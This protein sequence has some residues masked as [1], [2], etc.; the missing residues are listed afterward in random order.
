MESTPAKP[1]SAEG[2]GRRALQPVRWMLLLLALLSLA[3]AVVGIFVPVLPT[4]PFVLL[5]AWAA[6]R[7][8]P[9][10]EQS[11]LRHRSFGPMIRDWQRSGVVGRPAKRAAT[12][13]MAL[14]ALVIVWVVGNRWVA[15]AAITCM[16]V[17]LLW[18]WRRP[19][20]EAEVAESAL[21]QHTPA[22]RG[23]DDH[24]GE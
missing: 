4:V 16:G 19:E 11:L 1:R 24:Q 6:T 23:E 14:S 15:A 22:Q 3:L 21:V 18:L 9:R 8:S 10:L 5:A 13:A 2:S 17:V 7:S 12:V 20:Q